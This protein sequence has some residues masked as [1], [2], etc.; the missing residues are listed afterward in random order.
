MRRDKERDG[1]KKEKSDLRK[2]LEE[3][4]LDDI[5]PAKGAPDSLEEEK[6]S[7]NDVTKKGK[8]DEEE[9]EL[10]GFK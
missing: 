1:G 2:K 10:R 6:P 8:K 9:E 3:E 4:A 5:K 7:L